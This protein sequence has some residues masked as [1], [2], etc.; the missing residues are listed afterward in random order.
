VSDGVY[1][2]LA[3]R[4]PPTATA[5]EVLVA[6]DLD[7][8]LVG[9]SRCPVRIA[10]GRVTPATVEVRLRARRDTDPPL[11]LALPLL[12]AAEAL[13]R[14]AGGLTPALRTAADGNL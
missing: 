13:P 7:R 12:M 6:S 4:F 1:H 5:P 3:M 14:R 8:C 2:V 11:V 9:A 10:D